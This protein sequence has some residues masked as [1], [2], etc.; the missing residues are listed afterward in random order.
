MT[1]REKTQMSTEVKGKLSQS[2]E[3]RHKIRQVYV[4]MTMAVATLATFIVISIL[5]MGIMSEETETIIFLN[6]Y[7]LGSKALTAAVQ[8]YAVT[9]DQ[10]YYDDYMREL[11][12]D[13]NRDIALA[14]LKENDVTAEE[15]AMIDNIASMSNNLV[16]LETEAMEAVQA[17]DSEKAIEAVFGDAYA[18]TIQDIN[19][20]TTQLISQVQKRLS[21]KTTRFEMVQYLMCVLF[22]AAFF[23][24]VSIVFK[25]LKF[26]ERE[27]LLP[28]VKMDTY[29]HQFAQGDF[30]IDFKEIAGKEGEVGEMVKS[31]TFMKQ[32]F[33]D[34]IGDIAYVLEKMGEGDYRVNPS[35]DYL[36]KFQQIRIS[37]ETIGSVMRE[38]MSTLKG[39]AAEIESGSD[40]LAK[41]AMGLA[42]GC[43]QQSNQVAE[44]VELIRRMTQSMEEQVQEAKETVEAATTA[45]ANLERGNEK[46]QQLK[47][48]IR[49]ISKCSEK[50]GTII[51]TI[52][53]IA[54]ET[55][56]LSLNAAIEAARAGEAGRGFAVVAEQ[57]KS[58]AEESANAAG[59][60]RVL[61]ETTIQAVE[62]G[63]RYADDTAASMLEVMD[64]AKMSTNLMNKMAMDLQDEAAHMKNIEADIAAVS[65]VVDDNSATA[66]E[67]AAISE[68]QSAQVVTMVN[69]MEK[70]EI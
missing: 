46:M 13:K 40:Q 24:L 31:L 14:G 50:I 64:G 10:V 69:M 7:R 62:K 22:V 26:S 39:S 3:L 70:F 51:A 42:D 23:G 16:P 2:E 38:T 28:I 67:T 5:N 43:T 17:G 21:E 66:Q 27:L 35:Q 59:E 52:E 32:S 9:G 11:D 29:L 63:I 47:E 1:D 56:L 54:S 44:I 8:A 6:Q 15:W 68:Q 33:T 30:D 53:D 20:E 4:L 18:D 37:L 34:M 58:L 48:A 65:E 60:T 41:A 61:I 45:G 12:V 55:N 36:G 19:D 49:E 25:T 57:V